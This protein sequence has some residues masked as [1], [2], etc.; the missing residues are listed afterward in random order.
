[1]E[2]KEFLGYFSLLGPQN[3]PD[4]IKKA[5]INIVNTLLASGSTMNLA[6]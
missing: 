3:T 2:D 4:E 1:M 6:T 5:S